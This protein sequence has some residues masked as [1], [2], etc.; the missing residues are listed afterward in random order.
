VAAAIELWNYFFSHHQGHD[1][2]I[3]VVLNKADMIS[4]Q[5]LLRVYGALMWSLGKVIK[6]PEVVRVYLGSFWDQPLRNEDTKVLLTAEMED[7]LKDLRSLPRNAAVRKI[8]EIVKRARLAKT[9]AHIISHLKSQM[10]AL[11]YKDSKQSELIENLEAEFSK[12]ATTK[13]IPRGDFPDLEKFK[14]L[15][16]GYKISEFPKLNMKMIENMDE[17]LG[18]D[19][20]LLM[21]QVRTT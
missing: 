3:R 21:K 13:Q 10:P 11:F 14:A 1:D 2:K 16:K 18:V 5:Q 12:L 6:S 17:V 4:A 15:L 19:I 8:N 20:P 9:H 7:L